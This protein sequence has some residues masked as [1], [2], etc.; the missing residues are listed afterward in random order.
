METSGPAAPA[1]TLHAVTTLLDDTPVLHNLDL[2][3]EA[4]EVAVLMG[5]S[6]AGKTT[7]VRHLAGLVEPDAGTVLIGGDDVF[8]ADEE[9]LRAIRRGMSVMLGGTSLYE[10]SLFASLTALD[11]VSYGLDARGVPAEMH[12]DLA[13]A[14]LDKL[15]LADLAGRL[16]AEM[17]A[18]ARRRLALARALVVEAPLL[19]LDEIEVGLDSVHRAR[20]LRALHEQHL[21]TGC[22]MLVTTHDIVLAR[23]IG[24]SLAVLCNGRIVARGSATEL[25]RGVETGEDFDHRFRISDFLGPPRLADALAAAGRT[26]RPRTFSIDEHVLW[27]GLAAL[28]LVAMLAAF[29]TLGPPTS[30]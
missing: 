18:H 4:G 20:V 30:F 14:R 25:L 23:E 27:V 2:T 24:E 13:M 22:T 10:S 11:N 17:P 15:G 1:V 7:L 19:V 6:G 12:R 8:A 9:R 5:P 26:A 21:R 3:V 16:P 28:V 29:L